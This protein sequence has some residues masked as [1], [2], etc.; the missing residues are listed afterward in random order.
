[1]TSHMT[2]I[3]NEKQY[4][5]IWQQIQLSYKHSSEFSLDDSEHESAFFGP[6][7]TKILPHIKFLEVLNF[8]NYAIHSDHKNDDSYH[9]RGEHNF[10]K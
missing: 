7:I 10:L 8:L 3:E 6:S 4:I 9:Q 5:C 2:N 1:M